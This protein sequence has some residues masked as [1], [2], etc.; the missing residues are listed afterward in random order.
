[1][2]LVDHAEKELR[3]AGLFDLDSDYNGMLGNSVL[4]LIKVFAAQGHSGSSAAM[5]REIF[6]KLSSFK[7]LTPI[8]SNPDEWNDVSGYYG[9]G[10]K[11]WQS[12]RQPSLFSK[13]GGK[14][15]YDIDEVDRVP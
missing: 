15:W 14:T 5:T 12:T 7:P 11:M 10:P 13:D 1:M 4:E 8:T 3:L 6:S 2:S 9:G